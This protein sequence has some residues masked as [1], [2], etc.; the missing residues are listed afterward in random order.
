MTSRNH[1]SKILSNDDDNGNENG[2]FV[3]SWQRDV[4]TCNVLIGSC[5]C[6]Q[7]FLRTKM[8]KASSK[9]HCSACEK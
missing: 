5:M 6:K 2:Q 1:G 9:R 4:T 7:Y 3:L 8:P